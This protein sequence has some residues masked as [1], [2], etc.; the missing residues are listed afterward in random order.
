MHIP[1]AKVQTIENES[2]SGTLDNKVPEERTEI[3]CILHAVTDTE[4]ISS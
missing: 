3:V 1:K 4:F 2:S